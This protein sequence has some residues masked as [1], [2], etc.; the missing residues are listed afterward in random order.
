V[1]G[2]TRFLIVRVAGEEYALP[3]A[4]VRGM[5]QA[6]GLTLEEVEGRG[7]LRYLVQMHGRLVPVYLAHSLLGLR[8]RTISARSAIVLLGDS[9]SAS[10]APACALLVDSISRMEMIA[11][12]AQ[13]ADEER[14]EVRL[15]EKWRAV[16]NGPAL[17]AAAEQAHRE[18]RPPAVA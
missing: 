10:G 1:A 5:V 15:G 17:V 12:T 4:Q 7:A 8:G 14:S 11:L 13:R 9:D 6:R 3:G 2:S 18:S 16:L